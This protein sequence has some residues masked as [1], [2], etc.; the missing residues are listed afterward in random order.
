MPEIAKQRR[1][2]AGAIA[3]FL[4]MLVYF[5]AMHANGALLLLL[6][7]PFERALPWHK[8]LAW[9]ATV[10]GLVHGFAYYAADRRI[11]SQHAGSNHF[12]FDWWTHGSGMEITGARLHR[13][14]GL[15]G[16]SCVFQGSG[17]F[18]RAAGNRIRVQAGS[19]LSR[20]LR[21]SSQRWLG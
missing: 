9:S 3:A 7:L 4:L 20:C 12:A 6:G 11:A 21:S 19:S 13:L 17:C 15:C 16:Q 14:P 2:G 18:K 8:M 1:S 10:Q 5:T